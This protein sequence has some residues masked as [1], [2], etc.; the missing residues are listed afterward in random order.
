M[1]MRTKA[2]QGEG[3]GSHEGVR[4]HGENFMKRFLRNHHINEAFTGE[5]MYTKPHS[6]Y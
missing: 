6:N 2:Y 4:T 5:I 1:Q 3:R